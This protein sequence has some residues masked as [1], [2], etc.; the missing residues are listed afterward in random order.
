MKAQHRDDDMHVQAISNPELAAQIAAHKLV[1]NTNLQQKLQL[2][3][4]EEKNG[5]EYLKT[6]INQKNLQNQLEKIISSHQP[7]GPHM[8]ALI[9]QSACLARSRD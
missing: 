4:T 1:M 2:L 3:N 6:I 8:Q 9:L 7:L 5:A